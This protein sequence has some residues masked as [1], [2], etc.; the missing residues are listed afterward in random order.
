MNCLLQTKYNNKQ[1]SDLELYKTLINYC[2]QE[3]KTMLH[4]CHDNILKVIGLSLDRDFLILTELCSL[5]SFAYIKANNLTPKAILNLFIQIASAL[6]YMHSKGIIHKDIKP[7]NILI[8]F[9]GNIKLA[10]FGLSARL[11]KKHATYIVSSSSP[12][13][14]FGSWLYWAPENWEKCFNKK[15]EVYSLNI[16]F[17]VLITKQHPYQEYKNILQKQYAS[18]QGIPSKISL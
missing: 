1:P 4:L 16:V 11:K 10:D 9:Q 17:A 12:F 5:D 6:S 13:E 8:D 15:S 3:A 2:L 7:E 18:Q 14:F